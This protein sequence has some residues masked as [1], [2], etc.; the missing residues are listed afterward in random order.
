MF[1]PNILQLQVLWPVQ[2]VLV[3]WLTHRKVYR[4]EQ[5][6]RFSW[7]PQSTCPALSYL[8]EPLTRCSWETSKFVSSQDQKQR[9][10]SLLFIREKCISHLELMRSGFLFL[11]Y[12]IK[13][14]IS[15]MRNGAYSEKWTKMNWTLGYLHKTKRC[16]A[17]RLL[18]NTSFF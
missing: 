4:S 12:Q 11:P 16:E 15:C 18:S 13:I 10:R 9:R 7:R 14:H 1:L 8:P 5:S 17:S 3:I 2:T 6:L